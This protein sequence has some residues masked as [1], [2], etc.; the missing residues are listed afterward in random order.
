MNIIKIKI[1][2]NMVRCY[3][4]LQY[5]IMTKFSCEKCGKGFNSKSHYTQHNNRKTPCVNENKV[6]EMIE[7]S[8]EDKLSKLNIHIPNR[9]TG[10][11]IT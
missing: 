8:V 11:N 2:L 5:L 3:N 7:K 6:K 4:I 10:C 9:S 1:D